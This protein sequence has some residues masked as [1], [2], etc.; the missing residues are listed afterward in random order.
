M[1]KLQKILAQLWRYSRLASI[2][3][4]LG[5][6]QRSEQQKLIVLNS[7]G[8]IDTRKLWPGWPVVARKILWLS[9][10]VLRN[11]WWAI[12]S[13][14][15]RATARYIEV[16]YFRPITT[17]VVDTCTLEIHLSIPAWWYELA[18]MFDTSLVPQSSNGERLNGLKVK[19]KRWCRRYLPMFI[20]SQ[21]D[22]V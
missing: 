16:R 19:M 6:Q 2:N 12:S 15:R 7:G 9:K 13:A 8:I 14:T 10:K 5:W 1:D 11:I 18:F 17:H 4:C 22:I 20:I 3:G 21:H